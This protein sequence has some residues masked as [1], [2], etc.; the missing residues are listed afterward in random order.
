[1]IIRHNAYSVQVEYS[2]PYLY[3]PAL[4]TLDRLDNVCHETPWSIC[5]FSDRIRCMKYEFHL[6][7]IGIWT[8]VAQRG[9]FNLSVTLFQIL[10]NYLL[11]QSLLFQSNIWHC[12]KQMLKVRRCSLTCL[13]VIYSLTL[14]GGRLCNYIRYLIL[15]ECSS[16]WFIQ[17]TK[18]TSFLQ[19]C[20]FF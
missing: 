15:T 5:H 4:H 2:W 12:V 8:V 3:R 17:R 13:R 9:T 10:W 7:H 11:K 1:M 6:W 18:G 19:V 14:L 20:N 16:I